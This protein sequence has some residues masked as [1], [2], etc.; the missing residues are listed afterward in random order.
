MLSLYVPKAARDVRVTPAAPID[1][2]TPPVKFVS[3]REAEKRLLIKAVE[4]Y[5]G[6]PGLLR[7]T[8]DLPHVAERR[9]DGTLVYTLT[10]QHQ[11]L[12][13]AANLH[14]SLQPPDGFV[15]ASAGPGWKV[16]DSQ[17]TFSGPVFRDFT[18]SVTVRPANS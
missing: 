12:A 14:V 4:A 7:Y 3:H 2:P 11:P 9:A 6:H 18:T 13:R 17:A 10:V 5:P 1:F 8:Y 16:D 15:V